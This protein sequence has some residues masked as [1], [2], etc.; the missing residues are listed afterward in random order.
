MSHADNCFKL[1]SDDFNRAEEQLRSAEVQLRKWL[2]RLEA[3]SS[4][5]RFSFEQHNWT[6]LDK[7]LNENPAEPQTI[8]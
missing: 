6:H 7:M 5:G 3:R 1:A 4:Y 2:V 8:E